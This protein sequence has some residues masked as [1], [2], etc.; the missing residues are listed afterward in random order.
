MIDPASKCSVVSG[1]SS[2]YREVLLFLAPFLPACLAAPPPACSA[3]LASQVDCRVSQRR[4]F[5]AS[6]P[7]QR[8][9]RSSD[10]LIWMPPYPGPQGATLSAS[11]I[12]A[13]AVPSL[14]RSARSWA[15][16]E[17]TTNRFCAPSSAPFHSPCSLPTLLRYPHVRQSLPAPKPSSE[18][19]SLE[20]HRRQGESSPSLPSSLLFLP[21]HLTFARPSI[22]SIIAFLKGRS[23]LSDRSSPFSI[24][25]LRASCCGVRA[26]QRR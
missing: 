2:L 18:G 13:A 3:S 25:C 15:R 16:L 26:Q 22:T 10:D 6:G 20:E 17:T 1:I 4:R 12:A 14:P 7:S 9:T 21:P 5:D 8:P 24:P 23:L 11:R 19:S